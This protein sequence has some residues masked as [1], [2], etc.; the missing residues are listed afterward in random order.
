MARKQQTNKQAIRSLMFSVIQAMKYEW[1]D[2]R[3]K[4]IDLD[5]KELLRRLEPDRKI[6]D[7]DVKDITLW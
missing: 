5:A 3:Q 6:T 4:T 1:T 2:R 7:E